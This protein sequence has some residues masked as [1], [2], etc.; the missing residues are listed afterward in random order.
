MA[1]SPFTTRPD[2]VGG[3]G[4]VAATHWI[5]AQAGMR[6]LELGGNAFDAAV[7][8]AFTL[9]VVMPHMNGPGGDAAILMATAD[10]TTQVVCGQGCAPAHLRRNPHPCRR[11]CASAHRNPRPGPAARGT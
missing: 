1:R 11:L 9:H 8:T 4:V 7:A 3:F 5:A 10:G 6:M 2:I